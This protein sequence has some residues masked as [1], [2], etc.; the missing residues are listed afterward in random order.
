[1][2][3]LTGEQMRANLASHQKPLLAIGTRIIAEN[4][5]YSGALGTVTGHSTSMIGRPLIDCDM[6]D[7]G[8]TCFYRHELTL[9]SEVTP[10]EVTDKTKLLQDFLTWLHSENAYGGA[11]DPHL[12]S[13]EELVDQFLTDTH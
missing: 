8:N 2:K 5:C 6:D 4:D 1:M 10:I 3:Q 7:S 13:N 12:E 9:E 11:Y